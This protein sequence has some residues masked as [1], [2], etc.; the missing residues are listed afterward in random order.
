ME[1]KRKD[2]QMWHFAAE[3]R[4]GWADV[5]DQQEEFSATRVIGSESDL[6]DDF[7]GECKKRRGILSKE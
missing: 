1:I 2:N 7:C 5:Y 6:P 3:V 4:C